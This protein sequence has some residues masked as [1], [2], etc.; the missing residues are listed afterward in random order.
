MIGE[1]PPRRIYWMDAAQCNGRQ[2]LASAAE[3]LDLLVS[4]SSTS[5]VSANGR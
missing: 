1:G 5:D 3:G 4:S 2:P